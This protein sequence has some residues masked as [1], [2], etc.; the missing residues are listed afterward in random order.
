VVHPQ[1]LWAAVPAPHHS[2]KSFP[3]IQTK[4]SLLK[5]KAIA[6]CPVTVFPC[7]RLIP[8]LFINPF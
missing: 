8:L 6:T 2:V 4:P 7:K 1:L 5:L 3:N